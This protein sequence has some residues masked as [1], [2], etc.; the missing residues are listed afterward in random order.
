M[1]APEDKKN[2]GGNPGCGPKTTYD[3]RYAKIA[4]KL[5]LLGKTNKEIADILC[6]NE[7]T[8][9]D[10]Q[11]GNAD[12][13]QAFIDGKEMADADVA[14]SLYHRAI[15]Y[16][17]ESVKIMQNNGVPVIVPFTQYYPPDT[18]AATRW[19]MN[20][21]PKLWRDRPTE[22]NADAPAPDKVQVDVVDAGIEDT[23]LAGGDAIAE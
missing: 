14:K 19:L 7:T 3:P 23:D 18:Q 5:C 13:N 4:Y 17:H 20:R 10:W 21:Q 2:V 8:I 1:S 11:K 22:E 15:G 9:Y 6:V 16:S 12:F